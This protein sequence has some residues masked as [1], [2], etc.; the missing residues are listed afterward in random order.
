MNNFAEPKRS[1][2]EMNGFNW[3]PV[4]SRWMLQ[5]KWVIN[6]VE[7]SCECIQLNANMIG[8]TDE[9]TENR[10]VGELNKSICDHTYP[11]SSIE[12]KKKKEELK[13]N[14]GIDSR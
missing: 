5:H 11:E 6:W 9:K 10:R 1:K 8:K 2:I 13:W 12:E 7:L 3:M 4:K 14:D